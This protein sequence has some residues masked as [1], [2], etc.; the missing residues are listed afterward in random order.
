MTNH[1]SSSKS[2]FLQLFYPIYFPVKEKHSAKK[3]FWLPLL[4]YIPVINL[5]LFTGWR[6]ELIK[7]MVRDKSEILPNFDAYAFI[8][9][10]VLIWAV[11]IGY[12]SI[13]FLI[14][15][16]LD[17]GL[18]TSALE[19]YHWLEQV[20]N[21]APNRLSAWEI[22]ESQFQ[23]FITRML[24]HS[25]WFIISIPILRTG[26]LRYAATGKIS[27]L[28][29]V[30]ANT[31]IAIKHIKDHA[32]FFVFKLFIY[33]FTW[34]LSSI[35][36]FSVVLSIFVPAAHLSVF[37]WSTGFLYGQLGKKIKVSIPEH[38]LAALPPE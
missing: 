20:I 6:F 32:T 13:S 5:I 17:S 25:I 29:N 21:D 27:T 30:P 11:G 2:K 31:L 4:A 33:A 16:G 26:F 37:Y 15:F 3:I 18:L 34:A 19:L 14:I 12:L 23:Q 7:N 9:N 1:Q 35:L 36:A 38:R 8:I 10:G 22:F 28:L 24:V